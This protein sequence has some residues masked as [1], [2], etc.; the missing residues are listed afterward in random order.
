MDKQSYGEMHI[1]FSLYVKHL[2]A[3]ELV[4]DVGKRPGDS[5]IRI[6]MT[7]E[8]SKF[9]F[10]KKILSNVQYVKVKDH[11]EH[12]LVE[13]IRENHRGFRC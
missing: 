5:F 6:K 3:L 13:F 12:V 7:F 1:C 11:A 10:K 9:R 2:K 4:S 8:S